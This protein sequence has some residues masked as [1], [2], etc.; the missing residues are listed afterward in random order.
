MIR[1]LN[2]PFCKHRRRCCK[3]QSNRRSERDNSKW[4]GPVLCNHVEITTSDGIV[5][6]NAA[7][8][9]HFKIEGP[10]TIAGVDN[11][12]LKDTDPYVGG[13]AQRPGMDVLWLLLEAR[14]SS[15]VILN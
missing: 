1:K 12:D 5:Q 7:N 3:N 2:Q 15:L 14:M 6:P 13:Y 4:A 11:A 8:R 9:L 10:G